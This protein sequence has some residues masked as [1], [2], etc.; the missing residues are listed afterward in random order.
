MVNDV[1]MP[2]CNCLLLSVVLNSFK[3]N[4]RSTE[5]NAHENPT[6]RTKQRLS[7]TF[8]DSACH[9][10]L[11]HTNYPS[12]DGCVSSSIQKKLRLIQVEVHTV[13]ASYSGSP[14]LN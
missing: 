7:R 2:K 6:G 5:T 14:A 9:D 4:G 1:A 10:H 11:G 8:R 12:G 3:S 13:E